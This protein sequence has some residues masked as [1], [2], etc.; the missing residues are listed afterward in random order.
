MNELLKLASAGGQTDAVAA[1]L[2]ESVS[3]RAPDEQIGPHGNR[4]LLRWW[5]RREPLRGNI[6]LHQVLR[7]DDDRALHDHPWDST[8]IILRGTM[9]EILKGSARVLEPGS[10][11]FRDAE[12]AH[13]LE[14]VSGPVWSLFIT[15]PKKRDWGFHCPNGW[16]HWREFTDSENG[17]SQI[18]RGCD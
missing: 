1:M 5:L 10:I 6:Y 4:Y 11:T 17:G 2:I 14:V 7:D 18:G 3:G 8:S 12:T 15:G 16:R 9:K 13:R